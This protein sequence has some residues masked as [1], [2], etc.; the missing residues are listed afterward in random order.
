[1][2][3]IAGVVG[4][5]DGLRRDD[6]EAVG[7]AMADAVAHRGPDGQGTW[8]DPDEAVVLAHRRL[9]VIGLGEVGAQPMTS[10]SGRW[11]ITYNGEVYNAAALRRTPRVRTDPALRVVQAR[12]LAPVVRRGHERV[13]H[14]RPRGGQVAGE[15]QAL[16]QQPAPVRLPR[17]LLR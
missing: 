3:G 7:T 10:R 12:H 16:E 9:A 15:R 2:C 17:H 4:V 11:T 14:R 1:M 8:T 13:P 5:P 6:L